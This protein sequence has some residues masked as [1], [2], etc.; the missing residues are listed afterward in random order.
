LRHYA[1]AETISFKEY[2]KFFWDKRQ[3]FKAADNWAGQYYCKIFMNALYGKFAADPR[4]Y[5]KHSIV[6]P[7]NLEKFLAEFA[8]TDYYRFREW[9]VIRETMADRE[10][11]HSRQRF[12]NLA[13][14]ASITGFVRAMLWEAI[15]K[16][17]KPFYCDTDSITAVSF[18]KEAV[19]L[20]QEIGEWE[21]E[22]RY[23]RVIVA[24]KKL[25]A[26]HFSDDK[27]NGKDVGRWKVRSKGVRL[28]ADDLIRIVQGHE[29]IFHPQA[30]TFS[31]HSTAPEFVPRTVRA[32]A[33]DITRVPP[34]LDPQ[35]VTPITEGDQG[36]AG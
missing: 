25:Y 12:Y 16:S 5:H 3:E 36:G 27:R 14:A 26:F 35:N 15:K 29:I 23:D 18:P 10:G 30:P 7:D 13:T 33:K 9:I 24:G 34:E 4:R 6:H 31:A 11:H 20:G 22:G 21:I 17:N 1:F 28:K 2:V 19:T 32:T 8:S